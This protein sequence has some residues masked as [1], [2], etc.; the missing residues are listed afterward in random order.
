MPH[1]VMIDGDARLHL[2][3]LVMSCSLQGCLLLE[4]KREDINFIRRLTPLH[5]SLLPTFSLNK[6]TFYVDLQIKG[7]IFVFVLF[8]LLHS[9]VGG[10]SA[11]CTTVWSVEELI[12]EE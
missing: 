10:R 4:N 11:L 5:S 7:C 12:W 3:Y 1:S 9:S 2:T 8:F 6:V